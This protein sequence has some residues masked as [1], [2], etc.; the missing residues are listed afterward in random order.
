MS[1]VENGKVSKVK[2]DCSRCKEYLTTNP[3]CKLGRSTSNN[4]Y[5][6]W[7]Y[8]VKKKGTKITTIK[9]ANKKK[10]VEVANVESNKKAYDEMLLRKAAGLEKPIVDKLKKPKIKV[11]PIKVKTWLDV[12]QDGIDIKT[13]T[14]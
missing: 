2:C 1:T 13:R 4:K 11:E 8:A 3:L 6:K 5:C 12:I 14:V 7:F 10:T 9:T